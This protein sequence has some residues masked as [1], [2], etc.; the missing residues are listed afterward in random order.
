M[1]N[2]MRGSRRSGR[3]DGRTTWR[4]KSEIYEPEERRTVT[5]GRNKFSESDNISEGVKSEA[6]HRTKYTQ[7]IN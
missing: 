3:P 2:L 6:N 1:S 5:P 7:D 4:N